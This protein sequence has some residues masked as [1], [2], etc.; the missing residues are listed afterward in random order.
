MIY[1]SGLAA[2]PAGTATP[3]ALDLMSSTQVTIG[4]ATAGLAFAGLISPG[5]F[6]I[7][8]TVP[9]VS[10]GSQPVVIQ[11]NGAKS[12]SGAMIAVHR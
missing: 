7:N 10:D 5:L 6:Q 1:G 11:V 12:A 8:A 2:S 3:P 4:G 9:N